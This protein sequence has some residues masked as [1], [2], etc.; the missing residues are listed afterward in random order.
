MAGYTGIVMRNHQAPSAND[1]RLLAELP[2]GLALYDEDGALV[3]ANPAFL[4]TAGLTQDQAC[5]TKFFNLFGDLP[6]AFREPTAATV[7]FAD[8]HLT[9]ATRNVP[10]WGWLCQLNDVTSWVDAQAAA[11]EVATRDVLTG[12]PN[13]SSLLPKVERAVTDGSQPT[14]LLMIDL[15]RFKTV[16]DT[17]GHPIGDALL[18]KV[19]D[20]LKASLRATDT[21]A[22]LGGDEFAVLQVGAEQPVGAETL[23]KR[24]VEV[25][26]RPYVI[27]GHMIDVGAS[28]GVA[29]AST[30][31]VS[32]V[33]FKQADIALYRAKEGGR[34]RYTF[35]EQHMDE[36]MQARRSLEQDMRRALAFRQFELHYQPQMDIASRT[37]TGMEALLR[38]RHPTRGMV[39]PN[40]FIPLAEETGLIVP[41]GEWIIRQACEDAATW[42]EDVRVAV[43]VSAKQL[44]SGKLVGAVEDALARAG[45][46]ASR[47]EVEITESVLMSDV[48][49]CVETL[50]R[51]RGLG[52]RVSMDDFGT[53]YSSLSYLSSFPFDKIKI[54]QSF[55]R[56][57]D[58]AKNEA[59]VRAITAIGKHLGMSTIAEGVET[60][61]QLGTMAL[62]GC[63]SVQGF[64]ISRPVPASEVAAL[65]DTLRATSEPI[66]SASEVPVAGPAATHET[67][68]F[69][70]V[71]Y[72]RNAIFGLDEE[73]TSSVDAIL[74][75]SQRNN[76]AVGVTGALM[77]TDGFFAQVLEGTMDAVEQVF[78]RIQLDERHAEVRLLSFTPVSERVF[79]NWA[80]AFVGN[81]EANRRKFGHYA[82]SSG[83]DFAA[84]NADEMVEHL[85]RF[86]I[87]E[88][89]S[90]VR[91]AA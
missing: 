42:P 16:N 11:R 37:V 80:M 6:S 55:V 83:F 7:Q 34:G 30:S 41:L 38:W 74:S 63:G 14:A 86:L 88:E 35:F 59:I 10:D 47:L 50:H 25:L 62:S 52:A 46:A 3:E 21:V 77:F 58:A 66:V 87:A 15:D 32:D 79:P 23:A 4:M 68:L 75:A 20:R 70:L 43:N 72:S 26:S 90:N 71:Y 5:T 57:G 13:R 22:R 65:F 69:R 17:L 9:V 27:A 8:R 82:A 48:S 49:G 78:E 76:A 85:H 53:G 67:D 54:D 73:V 12:L 2:T 36:A 40:D 45:I 19:A 91:M 51:L 18:S 31:S 81:N 39:A 1:L 84:V 64:L 44:A 28:I 29:I 89:G 56:G 24:L 33:L 61:A 60:E